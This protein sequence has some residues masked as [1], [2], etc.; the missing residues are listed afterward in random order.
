MHMA[1][2]RIFLN[3]ENEQQSTVFL[4]G[5]SPG[6]GLA[7]GDRCSTQGVSNAPRPMG[8][9]PPQHPGRP[10]LTILDRFRTRKKNRPT[11]ALKNPGPH[12]NDKR[13]QIIPLKMS[14]ALQKL[15]NAIFKLVFKS[16]GDILRG[17]IYNRLSFWRGSRIF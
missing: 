14:P 17:M 1:M 13:L 4:R 15:K 3:A 2:V 9:R 11:K 8:I 6:H 7:G 5:T 12:E 10:F 16:P